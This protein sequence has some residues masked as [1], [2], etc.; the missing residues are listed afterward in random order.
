M[1]PDEMSDDELRDAIRLS[2]DRLGSE[3]DRLRL[4]DPDFREIVDRMLALGAGSDCKR[5]V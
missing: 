3:L 1:K 2:D 4:T 5:L